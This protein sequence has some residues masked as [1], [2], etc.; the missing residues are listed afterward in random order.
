MDGFLSDN[1]PVAPIVEND[2]EN[3]IKVVIVVYLSHEPKKHIQKSDV[4]A[5]QLVEIIPSKDISLKIG[6]LDFS[7]VDNRPE[8]ARR[9]IELGRKDAK[10]ALREARLNE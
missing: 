8:T 2:P 1:Q 6:K 4:G 10:K 7:G 9:L 5:R 3:A